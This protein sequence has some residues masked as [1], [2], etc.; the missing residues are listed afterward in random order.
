MD[1][2]HEGARRRSIYLQQRRT[3]PLS[4]L[5]LFDVAQMEPNCIRRSVST[6]A[7]QSLTMLN[8]QFVQR[9]SRGFAARVLN[10][11]GPNERD[12]LDL[13]F[14]L[15]TGR[16]PDPAERAATQAF[17]A[18]QRKL[19]ARRQD[20]ELR[21]WTDGCQMILAGNAFLYVE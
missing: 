3:Q 18:E 12:R 19:Y 15:A 2:G 5:E 13:A 4:F 16:P 10:H 1:A 21:A 6:V 20:A 9:R 11:A 7:L 14:T 17:M 8:D